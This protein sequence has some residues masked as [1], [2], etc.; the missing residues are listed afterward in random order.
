MKQALRLGLSQA[1]RTWPN[2]A[3]GCVIVKDG[4]VIA[5][6]WNQVTSHNDPTAHA[7]VTAI[8]Q[9]SAALNHFDLSGCEIYTSCE[10]CPMCL[11]AIYWARIGTVY[12]AA[13]RQ[14]AANIGFDDALIYDEIMLD[15]SNRK[16]PMR[17]L[18]PELDWDKLSA[19][20]RQGGV[21]VLRQEFEVTWPRPRLFRLF[22][23]PVDGDA[24]GSSGLAL[25]LNDATE[26]RQKEFENV[27]MQKFFETFDVRYGLVKSASF[28]FAVTMIGSARGLR[29]QGGATGVG[30]AATS[31][32]VYSAVAILTL[33]AFWAMTWLLGRERAL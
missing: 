3:V 9:A 17:Q 14:D 23:A 32:V 1:G 7:E 24:V 26:A 2:P 33:D 10:P 27:D 29:A 16:L 19:L 8:R 21:N 20:D 30:R 11:A 31:A 22:A 6:G 18:L 13:T 28:G 25:I 4:A 15:I 5:E 12:Y